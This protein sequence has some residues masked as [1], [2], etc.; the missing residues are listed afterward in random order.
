MNKSNIITM[1]FFYDRYIDLIADEVEVVEGLVASTG[2]L[3]S[4]KDSI[5]QVKDYS[6][7]EGK[8]TPKDILQHIIDTERIMSYR[9]LALARGEKQILL[10]FDEDEYSKTTI[11]NT[12]TVEDLLEEFSVVRA[13]TISLFKSFNDDMFLK[14]GICSGIDVSPLVFGFVCIGHAMHHVN[15][16]KE[17]YF[18]S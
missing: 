16:L 3:M 15:V 8:W 4:L 14:P 7:Q 18:K 13:S 5:L 2:V 1:P 10:G 17:K 11:A 9:A 6:Y 12:R